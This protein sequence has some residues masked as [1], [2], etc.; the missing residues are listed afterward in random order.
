MSQKQ[1]DHE[2]GLHENRVSR[3]NQ[4]RPTRKIHAV[5]QSWSGFGFL[6]SSPLSLLAQ[7]HVLPSTALHPVR[8]AVLSC[9]FT[10]LKGKCRPCFMSKNTPVCQ[11]ARFRSG[12]ARL[13]AGPPDACSRCTRQRTPASPPVLWLSMLASG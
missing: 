13:W 6:S 1:R 3:P 7:H 4:R 10:A 8:R 9:A 11:N 2:A 5:V 12:Q